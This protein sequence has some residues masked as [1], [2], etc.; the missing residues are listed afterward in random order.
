MADQHAGVPGD[1]SKWAWCRQQIDN[2]YLATTKFFQRG[3]DLVTF[4]H[5]SQRYKSV[6]LWDLKSVFN[7]FKPE[8]TRKDIASPLNEV[9]TDYIKARKP[10]SK[11][12][13]VIVMTDGIKNEGA[14]L[15]QIL[16]EASKQMQRPGEITV[17]FMQVGDSVFADELF[18]DLDRNLLAKGAK[19]DI[20]QF[21]SFSQLR[22]KGILWELLATL[23][24]VQATGATAVKQ[25]K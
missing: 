5:A 14:P 13:I 9:L 17:V 23:K 8:G 10:D 1:L 20:A 7:R 18:D 2:F 22:N 19:Y 12:L 25:V 6:S 24:D 3:F 15:Q 4:N 21:K 16:I 11:P